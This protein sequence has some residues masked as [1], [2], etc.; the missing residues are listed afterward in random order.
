MS[1]GRIRAKEREFTI[2]TYLEKRLGQLR[3]KIVFVLNA[4]VMGGAEK[5]AIDLARRLSE[6]GADSSFF[7]IRRGDFEPEGIRLSQPCVDERYSLQKRV[8]ALARILASESPELIVCVN[9][10]PLMVASVARMLSRQKA[11]I[12]VI[13]HSSIFRNRKE[14]LLDWFYRSFQ[15]RADCMV[16]ISENQRKLWLSRGVAPRSSVTILN[17]VDMLRFSL[18]EREKF[19]A[20]TRARLGFTQED[21]VLGC[22][23]VLRPEKNHAQL[24]EII[25][26][27]GPTSSLKALMV[28]DGPTRGALEERASEMGISNRV[29]FVGAH[30]DVRPYLAAFDLGALCSVAIETLSLAALE[31]LAM[32]VPMLMSD[33]GGA[34]EIVNGQ[35]G[36]V[37]PVGDTQKLAELV[38]RFR[39]ESGS[40]R[41]QAQVR[42][43]VEA[44]FGHE[45]MASE[46]F[47]AFR[48]LIQRRD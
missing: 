19:R 15:N 39:S 10:R 16:F 41:L 45:R 43:S 32:G 48:E 36:A 38:Q 4:L 17:G 35:N 18:S 9:D 14:A 22:C 23:A 25:A 26:R 20:A 1:I 6:S 8:S 44:K 7:A 11:K 29:V 30:H 47:E 34:S 21:V 46:Y 27:L 28:G 42:A 33:I 3:M 2:S 31:A 13:E 37:F 12:V 5:H 24:L 40:D